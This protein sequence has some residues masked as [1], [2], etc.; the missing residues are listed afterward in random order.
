MPTNQILGLGFGFLKTIP[1]NLSEFWIRA[2]FQGLNGIAI[3]QSDFRAPPEGL[4]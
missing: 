1:V 2:G 3:N 4:D